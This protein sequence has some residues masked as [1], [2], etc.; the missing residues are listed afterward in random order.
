MTPR[1]SI[2]FVAAKLCI[3]I[4]LAW[5]VVDKDLIPCTTYRV[6]MFLCNN[7]GGLQQYAGLYPW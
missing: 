7:Q 4:C 6:T 5:P 3:C 2:T 1:S